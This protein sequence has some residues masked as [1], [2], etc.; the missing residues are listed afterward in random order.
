[1]KLER[2]PIGIENEEIV[3]VEATERQKLEFIVVCSSGNA[4]ILDLAVREPKF[5]GKLSFPV[6]YSEDLLKYF[7]LI[8]G[9]KAFLQIKS[10]NNYVCITQKFGLHGVVFDI[11]NSRFKKELKRGDYHVEHC[12][13]PI[14]FY[15]DGDSTYLIHG[16]DWN[17]LDITCLDTDELLTDRVVDYETDTNY[18]DYFHSSLLMS[19]DGKSFTSNGWHWHPYG[20]I[21]AYAINS[22]LT[23]FECS[24]ATVDLYKEVRRRYYYEMEWDRPLCWLDNRTIAVGLGQLR[25][26]D[27]LRPRSGC[28]V[29]FY[30]VEARCRKSSFRCAGFGLTS[31]GDVL[32]D[33]FYDESNSR[34]IVLH[35]ALGLT[36]CDLQ[37][38]VVLTDAAITHH[39]YSSE[40]RL[41]Y[42]FGENKIELR[43]LEA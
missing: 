5:I 4:Y 15:S 40:S 6:T 1:M 39:R 33:L 3:S 7:E 30:D 34:L 16:T 23:S 11:E 18:F 21:T 29:L 20:K 13:F 28:G 19:P 22:F 37:G 42:R 38:N 8:G 12:T 17:R 2:I 24:N 25:F 31:E 26:D 32:G 10:Y 35:R 41:F 14:A 36:I 27:G 43:T 9:K